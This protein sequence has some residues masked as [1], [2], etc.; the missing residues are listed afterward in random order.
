MS[1]WLATEHE[2]PGKRND[3]N[4]IGSATLPLFLRSVADLRSLRRDAQGS[5]KWRR[6][7]PHLDRYFAEPGRAERVE[8]ALVS[9]EARGSLGI[10]GQ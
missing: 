7:W 4:A 8:A 10:G 3:A 5:F 9:A 1:H 6:A 2:A